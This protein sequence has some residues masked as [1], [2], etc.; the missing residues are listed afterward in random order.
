MGQEPV[1]IDRNAKLFDYIRN[2]YRDEQS[3]C[4]PPSIALQEM[5][6]E[7]K[8]YG[9]PE[10]THITQEATTFKEN[11][12]QARRFMFDQNGDFERLKDQSEEM[13]AK[14]TAWDFMVFVLD[15][16]RHDP[17]K[18]HWFFKETDLST[19]PEKMLPHLV[20]G[21]WRYRETDHFKET[22]KMLA[23]KNGFMTHI[24]E[25]GKYN[26]IM[27]RQVYDGFLYCTVD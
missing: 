22:L 21:L 13:G 1:F 27:K 4:I 19:K 24:V 11:C 10:N 2:W 17:S 18:N 23:E 16:K 26:T 6:D 12:E 25:S 3:I 20:Y 5:R 9:I 15:A 14:A 7:L 8:F